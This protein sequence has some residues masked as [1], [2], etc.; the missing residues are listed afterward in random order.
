MIANSIFAKPTD[1]PV[2]FKSEESKSQIDFIL[3]RRKHLQNKTALLLQEKNVCHPN[4]LKNYLAT[5]LGRA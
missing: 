4:M 5:F 3:T 2:T 1:K